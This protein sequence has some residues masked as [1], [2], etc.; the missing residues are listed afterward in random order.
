MRLFCACQ[1]GRAP[2]PG[3]PGSSPARR[4]AL[5]T[6]FALAWLALGMGCRPD[7]EPAPPSSP[8]ITSEASAALPVKVASTIAMAS[9]SASAAVAAPS[10]ATAATL[11]QIE[12]TEDE[13]A[14]GGKTID[15]EYDG[16]ELKD[17]AR[18]YSGR[19][20]VHERALAARRKLPLVVF[21]HGLNKAL[22]PHRWMGGGDEGDVRKI[23][24]ALIREGK[25][26]PFV[27]AGPGSVKKEAVSSP[28][29]FPQ[30]DLRRFVELVDENLGDVAEIDREQIVVVGHS[31]AGC[32]AKGG[33][34]SG[35]ELS[36]APLAI[37]SIDTCMGA[38]LAQALGGADPRTHV[39]V[40]WQN[41]SWP[42]EFDAFQREL[43]KE[44]A[45][46]PKA[47][48][49][50]QVMEQL[51]SLAK[52]HDATVKQTFDK[53]LPILLRPAP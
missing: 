34:V 35:L 36:P 18:A 2:A 32:S 46:H 39:V 13:R 47:E 21:F 30:F 27:L 17:R 14:M 3:A 4:S 37:V 26:A 25:V 33:I 8:A 28:A 45:K 53:H 48:G 29:S 24:A 22:I 11:P 49:T 44:A 19:I 9:A 42:R 23:S 10:S 40:T 15:F 20:F 51:P 6:G 1:P 50:L 52:P 38:S 7:P 12:L 43:K 31:G 41:S 16:K 5:G